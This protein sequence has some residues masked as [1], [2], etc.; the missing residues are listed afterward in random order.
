MPLQPYSLTAKLLAMFKRKKGYF[1]LTMLVLTG[2]AGR[3]HSD[4]L[5]G[6]E[7]RTLI[8]EIKTTRTEFAQSIEGLS[9][10]QLSFRSAKD[11]PSIRTCVYNSVAMEAVLWNDARNLF[12]QEVNIA[13]RSSLDD[14]ALPSILSKNIFECGQPKFTTVKEAMKIHKQVRTEMLRYLNT[15]TQNVRAHVVLT[16]VG[17]LDGYQLML[18]TTL[19]SK[20]YTEK[21][22]QIK[23][24]PNFPK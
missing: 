10:E 20:Y 24:A 16:A 2:L 17:N 23:S 1:L 19:Y 7:R 9:D 8:K 15:S 12:E 18:L 3:I 22:E 14:E 13:H 11:Q 21:I 4:T 6:K 5:T